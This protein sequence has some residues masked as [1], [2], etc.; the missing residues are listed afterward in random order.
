MFLV[1][2]ANLNSSMEFVLY[3]KLKKVKFSNSI[4]I[5]KHI[6]QNTGYS[7]LQ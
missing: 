2:Y 1:I 4:K 7:A 3:K 6:L 5:E